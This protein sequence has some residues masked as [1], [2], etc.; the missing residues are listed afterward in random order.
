MAFQGLGY[1]LCDHSRFE[2]WYERVALYE[3]G[4][5]PKH[6]ARQLRDGAWTS[7]CGGAED[8][9]HFTLDALESYGPHPVKAEYGCPVIYM[10][11]LIVISWGV[12]I[13][14]WL[15]WWIESVWPHVG[16]IV[17]RKRQ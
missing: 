3:Q 12:R 5:S 2:F 1:R 11:R 8:I 9:T 17:W 4:G 7:K 10:K 16:F 14:Q 6:M 13:L 15:E